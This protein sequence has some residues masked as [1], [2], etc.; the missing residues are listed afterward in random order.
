MSPVLKKTFVNF[1]MSELKIRTSDILK[2]QSTYRIL[3][4][5]S[6]SLSTGSIAT[7][8]YIYILNSDGIQGL[9]RFF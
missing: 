3:K 7:I 4:I 8:L 9:P 5:L 2:V 6:E 1:Q